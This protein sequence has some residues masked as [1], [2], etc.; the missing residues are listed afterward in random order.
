[1]SRKTRIDAHRRLSVHAWQTLEK[2]RYSNLTPPCSATGGT[3]DEEIAICAALLLASGSVTLAQTASAVL[4]AAAKAMGSDKLTTIEY[5]GN[6]SRY[7][8]G[9]SPT[10]G[11]PYPRWIV[12][13]Y[14]VDINYD[15]KSMR[16]EIDR[17]NEDG[18]GALKLVHL[19]SGTDSWDTQG[20]VQMPAP[21]FREMGS[22]TPSIQERSLRIWLTP[23]G[24]IRAAQVSNA[25]VKSHMAQ[26][27]FAIG[28]SRLRLGGGRSS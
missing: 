11:G 10:P 9:Q 3:C 15:A 7:F 8:L 16:E 19:I 17:T 13:R 6:G 18:S 28:W 2:I 22:S 12:N 1:V 4:D 26:R 20:N 14:V 21:V 24:L 5:T 25:T 27:Q 23:A